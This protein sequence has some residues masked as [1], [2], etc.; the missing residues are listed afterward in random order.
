[1]RLGF[2]VLATC[3]HVSLF[4]SLPL[5]NF[6]LYIIFSTFFLFPFLSLRLYCVFLGGGRIKYIW[7]ICKVKIKYNFLFSYWLLLQFHSSSLIKT[8]G[9]K[10]MLNKE[11]LI[12]ISN[13]FLLLAIHNSRWLFSFIAK[14][15]SSG[16]LIYMFFKHTPIKSHYTIPI[17]LGVLTDFMRLACLTNHMSYTRYSEKFTN[18]KNII[19]ILF[20]TNASY[21]IPLL[22]AKCSVKAR[23]VI[24][25][26]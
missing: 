2:L 9:H 7:E 13:N 15:Q 21:I 22:G 3:Y 5:F 25:L 4:L 11:Q 20:L 17:F 19:E 24:F 1:M 12:S 16:Q 14:K 23:T 10:G 18:W 6:L 26:L 8:F